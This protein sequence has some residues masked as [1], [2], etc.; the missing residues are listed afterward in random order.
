MLHSFVFFILAIVL[1]VHVR[2]TASDYP[3][4]IFKIFLDQIRLVKTCL[5]VI[6]KVF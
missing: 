3:F 2:Y 6:T 1:S 4:G 5:Y